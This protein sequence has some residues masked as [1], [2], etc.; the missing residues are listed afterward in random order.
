M[1][2][3]VELKT[4]IPSSRELVIRLPDDVPEG[5]ARIVLAVTTQSASREHT[6]GDLG[7]SEFIGMWRDRDD[8]HDSHEFARGL[9]E[10][11]W[12]RSGG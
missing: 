9:R 12:K 8:I 3:T 2:R 6:L 4:R 5:D 11:A 7:R 10:K 1:I